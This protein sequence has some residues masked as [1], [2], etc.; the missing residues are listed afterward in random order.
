MPRYVRVTLGGGNARSWAQSLAERTNHPE[1]PARAEGDVLMFQIEDD[2]LTAARQRFPDLEAAIGSGVELQMALTF[3]D[4][5]ATVVSVEILEGPLPPPPKS[6][7]RITF[8][9]ET[10]PHWAARLADLNN[11]LGRP[12]RAEGPVLLYEIEASLPTRLT[13]V[14]TGEPAVAIGYWLDELMEHSVEY[15]P[16]I[17]LNVQVLDGGLPPLPT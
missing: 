3:E 13:G 8:G 16:A 9:G 17:V 7:V 1:R 2:A 5:P 10:G 14:N 12:A 6:H 4:T 15:L 11:E